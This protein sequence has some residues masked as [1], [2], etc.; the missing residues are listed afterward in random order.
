MENT[1]DITT[2]SDLELMKVS[3]EL[4]GQLSQLT[5]NYN[6]VIAEFNK[7]KEEADKLKDA[8]QPE[9]G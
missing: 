6:I 8:T 5:A 9:A 1:I 7:R 4:S 3:I 2:I